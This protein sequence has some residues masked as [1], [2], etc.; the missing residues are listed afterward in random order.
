[1]GQ[2]IHTEQINNITCYMVKLHS[3]L[4]VFICCKWEVYNKVY[5]NCL[6]KIDFQVCVCVIE[7]GRGGRGGSGEGPQHP[8]HVPGLCMPAVSYLKP[9]SCL[10]SC[11]IIKIKK[12]HPLLGT[13]LYKVYIYHFHVSL[14][15]VGDGE[16]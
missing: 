1:M 15:K 2:V 14:M 7:R 5:T 8:W 3:E 11:K 16:G 6:L 4:Y 9:Q 10:K 12:K 13:I